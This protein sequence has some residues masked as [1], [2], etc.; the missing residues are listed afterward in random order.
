LC[1]THYS[2]TIVLNPKLGTCA[3]N[4]TVQPLFKL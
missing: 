1:I 4:A 2:T 3:S